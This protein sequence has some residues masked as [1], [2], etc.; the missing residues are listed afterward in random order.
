MLSGKWCITFWVK[1]EK[2]GEISAF[3][4]NIIVE[5]KSDIFPYSVSKQKLCDYP[6]CFLS[7]MIAELERTKNNKKG[8][9]FKTLQETLPHQ[10]KELRRDTSHSYRW[11]LL[12]K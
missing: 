2:H 6:P 5:K 8:L 7:K 9:K 3:A 1:M 12:A 4:K 11:T 10:I